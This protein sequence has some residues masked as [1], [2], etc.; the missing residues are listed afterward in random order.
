MKTAQYHTHTKNISSANLYTLTTFSLVSVHIM[1]SVQ[2]LHKQMLYK[3]GNVSG[4][5]NK[6]LRIYFFDPTTQD[7]FAPLTAYMYDLIPCFQN[8]VLHLKVKVSR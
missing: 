8:L 6:K 5:I 1:P 4:S 3:T 7:M 2:Q